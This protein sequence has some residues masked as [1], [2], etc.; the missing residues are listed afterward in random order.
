MLESNT[1]AARS[2]E[3]LSDMDARRQLQMEHEEAHGVGRATWGITKPPYFDT[4]SYG[5][6]TLGTQHR[7]VSE[8]PSSTV[9]L[10]IKAVGGDRA[11]SRSVS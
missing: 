4:R 2:E 9:P 3:A 8:G 7:A 6:P 5:P 1:N 10:E 11:T